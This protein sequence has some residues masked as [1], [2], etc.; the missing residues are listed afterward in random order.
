MGSWA[1][2][3]GVQDSMGR[4][5]PSPVWAVMDSRSRV[6]GQWA[7]Q[8]V[9]EVSSQAAKKLGPDSQDQ[10]AQAL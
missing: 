5:A 8:T 9:R 2:A 6:A 3:T 7:S 10:V 1:P 4:G